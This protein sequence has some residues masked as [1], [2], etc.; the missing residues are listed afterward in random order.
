MDWN[1]YDTV[2]GFYEEPKDTIEVA[3]VGTSCV[4]NSIS[5]M[6]LYE[7]YGICAYNFGTE[8]QPL[9]ASYY[10][11]KEAY[12]KHAET[13]S[14]VVLDASAL[15]YTQASVFYRKAIEGMEF[16]SVK[17]N[18]VKDYSNNFRETIANLLPLYAYHDR[19]KSMNDIDFQIARYL[20]NVCVR[21]YNF[22]NE[23]Y[24]DS[25]EPLLIPSFYVNSDEKQELIAEGIDYF[26]R[27][28]DF[29]DTNEL[30]L[31]LV[32]L[33]SWQPSEHNA[34]KDLAEAHGL[35][36]LDFSFEP[37]LGEIGYNWAVDSTDAYHANYYGAKK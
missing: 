19:W 11:I 12:R 1:N 21:G 15:R 4:I 29:C 8:Q 2:R 17:Y 26:E 25:N 5:P 10:W 36:L 16:S 6:E 20:P 9:M 18:A 30:N 31:V 24:L 13:L 34:V 14:T 3:F 23:R 7:N 27:I 28:V 32:R 37:L 35:E 22:T 33:A